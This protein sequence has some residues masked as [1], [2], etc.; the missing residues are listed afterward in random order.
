MNDNRLIGG[1]IKQ[2]RKKKGLT[3]TQLGEK[4]NKS[5]MQVSYIETGERKA[6]HQTLEQI[7]EILEVTVGDFVAPIVT[8][9]KASITYGRV[10]PYFTAEHKAEVERAL[11]SFDDFVRREVL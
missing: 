10:S 4:L 8:T 6:S 2:I 11:T 5:T 3:Q 9:K 1:R 7:A